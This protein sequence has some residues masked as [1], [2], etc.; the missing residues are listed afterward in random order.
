MLCIHK[1]HIFQVF[2]EPLLHHHVPNRKCEP[3][4]ELKYIP[5]VKVL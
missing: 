2:Q 1:D 5:N 4:H 3:T